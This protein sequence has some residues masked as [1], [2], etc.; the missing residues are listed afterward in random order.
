MWTGSRLS[1]LERLCLTSFVANGHDV[2]LYTYDSSL[3]GVPPGVDVMDAREVLPSSAV[4]RYGVRAGVG[5]GSLAGFSDLFRFKLLYDRGGWW[6]DT[7]VVALDTFTDSDPPIAA[8]RDDPG[9]RSGVATCVLR[10][11]QRSAA[12]RYLYETAAATDLAAIDWGE[13]GPALLWDAVRRFG[14]AEWVACPDDYCPIDW[15]DVGRLTMP[16]VS[17]PPR[18]KAVHFWNEM[19]RRAALDKDAAPP[20]GSV[21]QRLLARYD[22]VR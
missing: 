2:H 17:L 10:L 9:G 18:A 12:A 3:Q 8:Q 19:W 20:R 22:L 13:I 16:G 14:L 1:Q 21:Y 5:R 4:T 11:E 6:V 7:D 15:S